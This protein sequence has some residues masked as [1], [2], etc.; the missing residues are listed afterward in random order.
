MASA[1]A[2]RVMA[3]A[4]DL[5]TANRPYSLHLFVFLQGALIHAASTAELA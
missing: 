5:V 4:S 3:S 2:R 1:T